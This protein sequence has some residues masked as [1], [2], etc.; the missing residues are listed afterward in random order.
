MGSDMTAVPDRT[1]FHDPSTIPLDAGRAR[2]VARD[3][4]DLDQYDELYRQLV[5]LGGPRYIWC[6]E[7]G[8]VFPS[9]GSPH[10]AVGAVVMLRKFGVG[11]LACH[12]RPI[13]VNPNL[14]S[15]SKFTAI[16][17]TPDAEDRETLAKN[18]GIKRV[19]LE[20]LLSELTPGPDGMPHGFLW[21][22]TGTFPPSITICPP[23]EGDL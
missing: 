18:L 11:H 13:E 4:F 16:F 7:A 14:R 5:M 15:Q 3:P 2:Y 6:D 17:A 12:T 23:L 22:N 19:E 9:K 10:S 8:V 1:D 20:G 21:C